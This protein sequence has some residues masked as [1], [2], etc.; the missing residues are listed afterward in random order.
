MVIRH[1]ANSKNKGTMSL[2]LAYLKKKKKNWIHSTIRKSGLQIPKIQ[3]AKI[4]HFFM[5]YT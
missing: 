3:L 1:L 5:T 4:H 2:K